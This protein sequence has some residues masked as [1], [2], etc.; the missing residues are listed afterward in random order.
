MVSD[1]VRQS[2]NRLL[3]NS[4]QHNLK[5]EPLEN[6]HIASRSFSSTSARI[7]LFESE[8]IS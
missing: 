8:T 3:H 6:V 1:Q 4:K 2:L 7:P 5:Q